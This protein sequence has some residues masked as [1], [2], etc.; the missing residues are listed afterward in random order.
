MRITKQLIKINMEDKTTEELQ[1]TLDE[2]YEEF[3]KSGTIFSL[4][5]FEEAVRELT[6]RENQ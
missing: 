3:D 4:T 1:A 2:A 5:D 6:L